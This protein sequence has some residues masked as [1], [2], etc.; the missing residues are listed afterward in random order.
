M[1]DQEPNNER[2]AVRRQVEALGEQHLVEAV[3][4]HVARLHG[5]ELAGRGQ[6]DPHADRDRHERQGLLEQVRPAPA[7]PRPPA[8]QVT[9]GCAREPSGRPG[10][11][12]RHVRQLKD[13]VR[14][15]GRAQG[16]YRRRR[17]ADQTPA[18]MAAEPAPQRPRN[19]PP[20]HIDDLGRYR[21]HG[22]PMLTQASGS[23]T[24]VYST[25]LA[26]GL[27]AWS[28]RSVP[29]S[30][31]AR[32]SAPRRSG[33]TGLPRQFGDTFWKVTPYPGVGHV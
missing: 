6:D 31:R 4:A 33:A 22:R 16:E 13:E 27:V 2:Q 30:A 1:E 8:D 20:R 23:V 29:K 18:A 19:H 14:Q 15:L 17:E 28:F 25:G 32:R 21:A 7:L 3:Q 24:K 5:G 11:P 9:Y 12:G 26:D 10:D